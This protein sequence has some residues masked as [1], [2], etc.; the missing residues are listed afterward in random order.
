MKPGGKIFFIDS[1]IESFRTFLGRVV[2]TY[3]SHP[4]D[5][6]FSENEFAAYLGELGFTTMIRDVYAPILYYFVLVVQK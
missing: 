5:E 1:P 4:Y 2:R 6:M 3:T